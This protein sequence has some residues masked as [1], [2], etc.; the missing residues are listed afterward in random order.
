MIGTTKA[1]EK[2][3]IS[4]GVTCQRL[5]TDLSREGCT[6]LPIVS[7]YEQ[8]RHPRSVKINI[9]IRFFIRNDRKNPR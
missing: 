3:N 6:V 5:Y 7:R 8:V 2:W 1:N 9:D 4:V